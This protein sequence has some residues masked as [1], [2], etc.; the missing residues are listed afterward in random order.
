MGLFENTLDGSIPS[1]L[2]N[3]LKLKELVLANNTLGGEIPREF[4][5]LVSL[6]IFQIQNNRFNS[7]K[8]LE[9]M[10]SNQFLVFDYDKDYIKPKYKTVDFYNSRMAGSKFED[11]ENE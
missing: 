6:Q 7:S 9:I 5:Q 8:N 2:G 1:E 10:D 3:L 11:E 4:G